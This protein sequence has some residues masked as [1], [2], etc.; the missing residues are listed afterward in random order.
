MGPNR[1]LVL[2]V[3][4]ALVSSVALGGQ[5]AYADSFS[6]DFESGL[7]QWTGRYGGGHTG[8]LATDPK[9]GSNTALRFSA[10][11]GGGDLFTKELF[12]A[13]E[14]TLRFDYL[15]T[16]GDDDS[17]GFVGIS[18]DYYSKAH[19]SMWLFATASGPSWPQDVLID[20]GTWHSYSFI[21]DAPWDFH[22]MLEDNRGVARDAWFDNFSLTATPEPTSVL[23]VALGVLGVALV[24]RRR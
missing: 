16:S 6:D 9:D 1:A 3:A 5:R 8:E 17:G 15:G 2:L 4:L 23:L 19:N 18:R 22:I 21:I 11:K 13:G 12:S 20:D 10:V 7:S 24:R 14:Y